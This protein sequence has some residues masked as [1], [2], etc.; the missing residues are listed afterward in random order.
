MK[1]N[2]WENCYN[3]TW[4]GVITEPSFV[5]PAKFSRGLIR[6]IYS[7][8]AG[9]GWLKQGDTILDPFGGIGLGALHANYHGFNWVGVELEEKFVTLG[10]GIECEGISRDDF[11]RFYGRWRRIADSGKRRW[12]PDCLAQAEKVIEQNH[13]SAL[14]FDMFDLMPERESA[15]YVRNSGQVPYSS[16]HHFNGNLGMFRKYAKAGAWSVL[17]QGDS[18]RL[19]D[20]VLSAANG[21]VS[22]PPY[23]SS[24]QN[25][26][27]GWD[28]IDKGK[29]SHNRSSKNRQASYGN[30]FGQMA[31][32]PEG[33]FDGV[34]SSPPYSGTR[35]A[36]NST[37][38]D[39]LKLYGTYRSSGGGMSFE[40]FCEQQRR[41]SVEYGDTLGQLSNLPQGAIDGVISS[42]PFVESIGS[43]DPQ[44]RGGV[45][46]SDPK[47]ANDKN[48]TGSY[49]TST[50]QIG[51]MTAGEF[52]AIVG[53]PPY[54]GSLDNGVVDKAERVRLAREKG[55]SNSEDISPVDMGSVGRRDFQTGYGESDGNLG[56]MKGGFDSIVSSP[57][58]EKRTVHGQG[59]IDPDK[60]K[61]PGQNSQAL[62]MDDYGSSPGQLS[63]NSGETFWGAAR[64]VVEQCYILLSPDSYAIW[65]CKD[66]VRNKERVPFC[67][68]WRILCESVGFETVEINRAMLVNVKGVRVSLDLEEENITVARKGFFRRLA[69]KKG[70]PPIDWEEVI[71]MRKP[72]S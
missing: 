48:L 29:L 37:G 42:P 63:S 38:I 21:L 12:C 10:R 1:I 45:L 2:V 41:H 33:V 61:S 32:M 17:L 46:A 23:S 60:L 71:V 58:Y 19:V 69:E 44:K 40:S 27:S 18:R 39:L 22:S 31:D 72:A 49:G 62:V 7:H 50:G 25:Y 3:D 59:G 64:Q 15:S 6:R 55:I 51:V 26:R 66:F 11:V 9:N 4:K 24:N 5:H 68:M 65:V 28:Y 52:N 8:A 67:D 56:C 36:K 47:R 54:E 14:Q 20:T 16:P 70:S 35:V 30:Q 34:V 43:D 53:S 13:E 57:P